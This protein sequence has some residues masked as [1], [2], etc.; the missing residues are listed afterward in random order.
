VLLSLRYPFST[1]VALNGLSLA[2]GLSVIN[3]LEDEYRLD[4]LKLKWP[5]DVYFKDEKLAGILI[6]NSLQGAYQS[7]IIGLGVN[8]HLP[9]EFNC[10]TPWTDI[11]RLS[12]QTISPVKLSQSLILN[13]A[14]NLAQFSKT[15]FT[16]FLPL[17]QPLDYLYNKALQFE[18]KKGYGY[19]I[20]PQ[21]LLQ[22]KT[23]NNLIQVHSSAKLA[24]I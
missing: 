9:D 4:Q 24:I 1:K 8:L 11:Y 19:G 15:G 18:D 12:G 17:W 13:L 20:N 7:S 14:K 23:E 3:I 5:N 22:I 21:G 2:A 16:S 6:E 10:P